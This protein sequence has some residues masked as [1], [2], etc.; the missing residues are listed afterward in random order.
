MH[1]ATQGSLRRSKRVGLQEIIMGSTP[2]ALEGLLS[3]RYFNSSART[4]SLKL[5]KL[6]QPAVVSTLHRI[7]PSLYSHPS[8]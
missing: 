4:P 7:I 8:S 5:R 6:H 3:A 1:V 2:M